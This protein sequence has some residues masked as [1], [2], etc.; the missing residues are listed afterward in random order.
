MRVWDYQ[1]RRYDELGR[2]H[3]EVEWITVKPSA[4]DKTEID[5]DIDTITHV[6]Y[7]DTEETAVKRARE[8]YAAA[9]GPGGEG[10][11]WGIV[12][13]QKE[14]LEWF[15]QEDNVAHWE[16]EGEFIEISDLL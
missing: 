1:H 13:V 4:K 12:T 14:V 16:P 6:E 11:C 15:V 8:I 7:F 3:F 9:I 5:P 10:L 2:I